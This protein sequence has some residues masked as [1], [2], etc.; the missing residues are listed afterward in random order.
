MLLIRQW[1]VAHMKLLK[2]LCGGI[3]GSS[4]SRGYLRRKLGFGPSV[5]MIA[6]RGYHETLH[7]QNK[8]G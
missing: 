8:S 4:E 2:W 1:H 3:R 5:Q 6:M 7:I